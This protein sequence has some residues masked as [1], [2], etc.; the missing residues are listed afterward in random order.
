[1]LQQL[2]DLEVAREALNTSITVLRKKQKN[3]EDVNI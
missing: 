3:S 1:M 2:V